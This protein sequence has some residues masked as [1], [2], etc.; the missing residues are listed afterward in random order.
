MK[1]H[2]SVKNNPCMIG[3]YIGLDSNDNVIATISK[4][5]KAESDSKLGRYRIAWCGSLGFGKLS[6]ADDLE[7]IS[8]KVSEYVDL[9]IG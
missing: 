6:Y 9:C 7:G 8:T 1:I 5:I 2:S 4:V 3:G